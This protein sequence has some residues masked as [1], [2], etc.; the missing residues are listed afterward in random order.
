MSLKNY[1]GKASIPSVA[2]QG[3]LT[4]LTAPPLTC[5]TPEEIFLDPKVT[6]NQI[7]DFDNVLKNIFGW[8]APG[9]RY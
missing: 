3:A 9:F 4:T 7:R 2:L 6:G 8:R 1:R 5:F